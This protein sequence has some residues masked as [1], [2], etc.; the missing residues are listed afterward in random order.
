MTHET[1]H[2]G[3]TMSIYVVE[4]VGVNRV[5]KMHRRSEDYD[6]VAGVFR[7]LRKLSCRELRMVKIDKG[8]RVLLK[9]ITK[10]RHD[11][12]H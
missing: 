5:V 9:F 12:K 8:T 2:A 6:I 7:G 10:V 11:P 1:Y 4:S 3:G